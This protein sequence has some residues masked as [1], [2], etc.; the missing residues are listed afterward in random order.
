VFG[1]YYVIFFVAKL[2][3]LSVTNERVARGTVSKD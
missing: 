2:N 3:I 1:Y